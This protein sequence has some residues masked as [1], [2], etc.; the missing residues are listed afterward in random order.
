MRFVLIGASHHR[1]ASQ[2]EAAAGS[3]VLRFPLKTNS[4]HK[5]GIYTYFLNVYKLTVIFSTL[6]NSS[7][8]PM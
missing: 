7:S 3:L 1:Q 8:F 6:V 5:E 4:K 2:T